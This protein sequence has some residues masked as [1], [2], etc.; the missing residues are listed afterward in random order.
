MDLKI[1]QPHGDRLA[2]RSWDLAAL[3]SFL[4]KCEDPSAALESC[5]LDP[6]VTLDLSSGAA[7]RHPLIDGE[8]EFHERGVALVVLAQLQREF[9][10]L[11][12]VQ[13][14][15]GWKY[16]DAHVLLAKHFESRA[17]GVA[18]DQYSRTSDD[19]RLGLAV[20]VQVLL[21]GFKGGVDL[22]WSAR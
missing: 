18:V 10:R 13:R 6:K 4:N 19:P 17:A 22:G 14:S 3:N 7:G 11:Q 16:A 12:V 21:Q 8:Q 2:F 15:I 9:D 1:H 20:L 5:R